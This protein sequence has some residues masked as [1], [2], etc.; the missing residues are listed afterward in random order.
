MMVGERARA[1]IDHQQPRV[2]PLGQRRLGDQVFGQFV[3]VV[4][5][6]AHTSHE[7]TERQALRGGGPPAENRMKIALVITDLD[8]GGAERALVELAVRLDR[9]QFQPIVISLAPRPAAGRDECVCR[10][11]SAGVETRFLDARSIWD[12]PRTWFRLRKILAAHQPAVVQT[13]LFHGNIL[14]RLAAAG[15][16]NCKVVSGIRVAERGVR[17]HGWLDRWTDRL[18]A[19]HVCV[20]ESVRRF[21]QEIVGLPAD[22]LLVIPNGVDISRFDS[23]KRADLAEFGILPGRKVVTFVGRLE[24]QKGVDFLLETAPKWLGRI[25][26]ADLLLVGKGPLENRLRRRAV[27]LGMEQRVHFAGWRADIPEILLAS[28]LLVLPSRWEGMPNVVLE[29]MAAGLP[30]LAADVE[31][32]REILGPLG[33]GQVVPSGDSL[34][35]VDSMV[36]ILADPDRLARF[37]HL[38]R[39]RAEA[40]FPLDRVVRAYQSLWADLGD[41]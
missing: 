19:K 25:P 9:D 41:R 7:Y 15:L 16:A 8:V 3:I 10:L 2:G 4:F 5:Y 38:N 12:F 29:A 31:G 17:W 14:G 33:E 1:A 28:V 23:E 13:F 32:V 18:V 30:V 26:D 11:E 40:D 36:G 22:K 37:A 20:S 24:H 27:E 39:E 21:A 6:P 34:N 35:W